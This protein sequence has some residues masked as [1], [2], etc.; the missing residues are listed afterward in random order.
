MNHI[1]GGSEQNS[2]IL[3]IPSASIDTVPDL[4]HD[5]AGLRV[6]ESE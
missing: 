4:G 1:M 6:S 5:H 2:Q 3:L